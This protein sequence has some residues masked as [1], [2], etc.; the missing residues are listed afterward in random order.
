MPATMNTGSISHWTSE[1]AGSPVI[2]TPIMPTPSSETGT[3]SR[4]TLSMMTW[5]YGSSGRSSTPSI[6]P[7]ST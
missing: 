1:N 7:W 6:S 4:F 3:S 2:A 5:R